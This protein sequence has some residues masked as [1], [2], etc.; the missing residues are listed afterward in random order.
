[1][2]DPLHI[3][4]TVRSA[5]VD[6]RAVTGADLA[7]EGGHVTRHR[8]GAVDVTSSRSAIEVVCPAGSSVTVSTASGSVTTRGRLGVVRVVTASGRV[9][10]EHAEEIEIR[11]VAGRVEVGECAGS[12]RV[13]SKSSR[14][15]V[16]TANVVELS[17]TS[18]RVSVRQADLASARTVSSR[19]EIGATSA[20]RVSAHTISGRVE[21]RVLGRLPARMHLHS[22]TG[23]VE[24]KVPE[25]EGGAHIEA[26]STSGSIVVDRG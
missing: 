14:I 11:T 22:R 4:I 1:M 2:G 23:A 20:A 21:V 3:R 18:G 10:V 8:D 6:V 16:G 19:I 9:E 5:R 13:T 15:E 7:V 24:R 12:C 17:S 25:G 26:S